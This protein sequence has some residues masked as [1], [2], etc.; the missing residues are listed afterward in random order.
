V[1]LNSSGEIAS[2][3]SIRALCLSIILVSLVLTGP[4]VLAQ[5]TTAPDTSASR[6][7]DAAQASDDEAKAR[8]IVEDADRIRFPADGFQVDVTIVTTGKDKE[9]DEHRYRVLSKGN[10][11]T[12]VMTTAPAAERGQILLM[13]GRD[14]WVFLP[15]VSQPVRLSLSQ[16][17][18]GQ[19]ANGDLA[20]ANF[21]GDYNPKVERTETIDGEKYFVLELAAIDRS[22]TYPRVVY[23]V[24]QSD[25]APYRAEFFSVS[26]RLLKTCIYGK[27]DKMLGKL[28]PT[29]LVMT[30]ALHE[31][32]KSVLEYR[33]MKLRE[34]PDKVFTKDYLKKLE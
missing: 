18:T 8:K 28:R 1:A 30:D 17:L 20:R 14:L 7:D 29:Q 33:D 15:N 6:G 27:Y 21:A 12:V 31:G 19:V 23:W 11:S 24:R 13:K 22:V 5:A 2:F 4:P 9:A 25:S 10:E 34:L 16:R 32:E 26:N 3:M